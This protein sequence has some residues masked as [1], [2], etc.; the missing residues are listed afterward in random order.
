MRADLG[1]LVVGVHELGAGEVLQLTEGPALAAAG[2][3]VSLSL[4]AASFQMFPHGPLAP[5]HAPQTAGGGHGSSCQWSRGVTQPSTNLAVA[6][7]SFWIASMSLAAGKQS[8]IACGLKL[9]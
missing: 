9:Y 3:C 5:R 7:I 4:V 8:F 1:V 6:V 2:G